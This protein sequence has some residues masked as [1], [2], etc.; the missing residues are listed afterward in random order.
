MSSGGLRL[1]DIRWDDPH[2]TDGYEGMVAYG[3]SKTAN[4]LFAVELDRRWAADG[5]RGYALHPGI[6]FGTNLAPSVTDDELRAMGILDE[7]GEPIIDPD[8]ELKTL[9]QA[10]STSVF[11][12][13]SPLLAD[14]GGV[15]LKDNDVAPLEGEPS[16]IAFGTEP[17]R[18]GGVA[19]YAVDPESARRLWELSEQ[20]LGE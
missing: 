14:I 1:S 18:V 19:P 20:L 13:T 17:I 9:A 10:A 7:A 11:A 4:V 5:I 6:A 2:F 12:A 8:R 15:Y 3:Q 16:D